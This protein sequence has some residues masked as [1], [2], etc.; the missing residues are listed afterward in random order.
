MR[1]VRRQGRRSTRLV[2]LR[3]RGDSVLVYVRNTILFGSGI[4]SD[5]HHHAGRGRPRASCSGGAGC[6]AREAEASRAS[7]QRVCDDERAPTPRHRT[8]SGRCEPRDVGLLRPRSRSSL[9]IPADALPR[10][11]WRGR[12]TP[13]RRPLASSA[14]R[15]GQ[16]SSMFD[17]APTYQRPRATLFRV[18][19]RRV[20]RHR[21]NPRSACQQV[22]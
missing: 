10:F 21:A 12:S 5:C 20:G 9:R 22:G 8:Q 16:P 3:F 4:V 1:V 2:G 19:T 6:V 14:P 7:V 13:S 17:A 15:V 11:S 18:I